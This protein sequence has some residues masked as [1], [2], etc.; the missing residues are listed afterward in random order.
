MKVLL[1]T[2]FI[3]SALA[4]PNIDLEK[5]GCFKDAP[6]LDAGRMNISASYSAAQAMDC[7]QNK[8]GVKN[9]QISPTILGLRTKVEHDFSI[10][11][12]DRLQETSLKDKQEAFCDNIKSL[13]SN[14]ACSKER[15]EDFLSK[16]AMFY[17]DPVYEF[18]ETMTKYYESLYNNKNLSSIDS[19]LKK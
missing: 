15:L 8:R 19:F 18:Y 7:Y 13:K 9:Y 12:Y 1:V 16:D 5:T 4:C 6:V 17:T 10:L 14:N 3:S 11:T 2:L